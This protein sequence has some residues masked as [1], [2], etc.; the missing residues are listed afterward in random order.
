MKK[1]EENKKDIKAE[2]KPKQE[3]KEK[4]KEETQEACPAT[5]LALN[6]RYIF[7]NENNEFIAE[8]KSFDPLEV[9]VWSIVGGC[10]SSQELSIESLD[11]Y[12]ITDNPEEV[13]KRLA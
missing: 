7:T 6:R 8:I 12:T 1:K 13:F 3:D 2:V 9:W 11:E 5:P 10:Q 4:I